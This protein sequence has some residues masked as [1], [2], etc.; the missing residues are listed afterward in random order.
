MV[1]LWAILVLPGLRSRTPVLTYHD[2][3]AKRD[4][5]SLWFDC[6]PTEFREQLDWMQRR[7]ARFLSLRDLDR[8]LTSGKSLPPR[9]IVLTF[10]DNYEGF[11]RYAYPILRA[12]RIPSAMFVHTGYVGGQQGRPKM[13]W[14]QLRELDRG[15]LVTVASQTVSHPVDLRL[16]SNDALDREFVE[17]KARLERELGHPVDY[18]AYPNGKYDARVASRAR[19]AGYRLAFTEVT[20]PVERSPDLWRLNRYVHT[21][22]RQAR[23]GW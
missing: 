2:F 20:Q 10:A 21:K 12:R 9:S 11:W 8:A 1:A 3:V 15:G 22:W 23:R 18:V 17:S 7:G 16:L 19:K 6:T 4:A 13:T 14:A 5:Q